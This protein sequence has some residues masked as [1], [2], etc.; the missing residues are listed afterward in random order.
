LAVSSCKNS[1]IRDISLNLATLDVDSFSAVI[2]MAV[3]DPG[4]GR[5]GSPEFDPDKY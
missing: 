5:G 4:K 3:A 1:Q 2:F